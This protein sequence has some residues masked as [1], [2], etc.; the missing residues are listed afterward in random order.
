M[1]PLRGLIM[2][3]TAAPV[4]S[5]QGFLPGVRHGLLCMLRAALGPS[6]CTGATARWSSTRGTSACHSSGCRG[7]AGPRE[8]LLQG[9]PHV[10]S[11]STAHGHGACH[12]RKACE[13][14]EG[15]GCV[16]TALQEGQ[17]LAVTRS[18]PH[19]QEAFEADEVVDLVTCAT[20]PGEVQHGL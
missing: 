13:P 12:R 14:P 15:R 9:H 18:R 4:G 5:A 20:D 2:G 1:L 17:D 19:A 6:S 11:T 7:A 3:G 16:G 10:A 8:C